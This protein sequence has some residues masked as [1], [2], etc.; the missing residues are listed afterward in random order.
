MELPPVRK[1][2]SGNFPLEMIKKPSRGNLLSGNILVSSSLFYPVVSFHISV[3]FK[4]T[5]SDPMYSQSFW[6]MN[7]LD[8]NGSIYSDT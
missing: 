3:K 6:H 2:E 7:Y 5:L 1:K 4:I 8:H